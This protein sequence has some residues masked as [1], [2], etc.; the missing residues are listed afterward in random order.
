MKLF[1]DEWNVNELYRVN[2]L[3]CWDVFY[4]VYV[5]RDDLGGSQGT[6]L[7]RRGFGFFSCDFLQSQYVSFLCGK[8]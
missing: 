3:C 4:N 6:V 5:C 7:Y 8:M 2:F 1:V